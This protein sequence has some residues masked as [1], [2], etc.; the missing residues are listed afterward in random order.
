LGAQ[1]RKK[2]RAEK[3]SGRD[4]GARRL[5]EKKR[6]RGRW[7]GMGVDRLRTAAERQVAESCEALAELLMTQALKGK[8]DSVKMLM[9]L[10]EEEKARK[11]EE[12]GGGVS[13][14]IEGLGFWRVEPEVGDVWVGEGWQS[15]ATGEIFKGTWQAWACDEW[16]GPGS[17]S[18]Q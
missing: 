15:A 9:K 6:R 13:K 4:D 18:S 1:A 2:R 12:G 3:E 14:F 5:R 16:K 8:L 10:A 11:E 7:K 17:R